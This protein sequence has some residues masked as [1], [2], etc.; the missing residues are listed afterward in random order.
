L[1]VLSS[2]WREGIEVAGENAL[3]RF[4][5]NGYNQIILNA[6]PNG[7]N[8]DGKPRMFGFTYLRLSDKLLN[9]PNFSTFKM[10]LK[11]MHANQ[12]SN[13]KEPSSRCVFAPRS[14]NIF[15]KLCVLFM[16]QEY[17]SEPERYNHELLPLERSRNDESL[18]MFMEETEPFDPFPWLD[19]TDM[20]IRP[21][22]SVL[23]LL[24]STFLRKKS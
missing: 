10:F 2:G 7:V 1:K 5:R 21:F 3:P 16:I 15:L 22:E 18:E 23:S 20:S 14:F 13:Q 9:E 8:Q 6:R 19:E 24:R 11:R 17:C 4:D 12:V